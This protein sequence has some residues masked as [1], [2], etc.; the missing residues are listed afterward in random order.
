M[1]RYPPRA[2][3]LWL[4]LP[5][6]LAPHLPWLGETEAV[7]ESAG[8]NW[9]LVYPRKVMDMIFIKFS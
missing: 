3:G 6:P 2:L 7:C 5:P 4:L 8:L 9:S 1:A